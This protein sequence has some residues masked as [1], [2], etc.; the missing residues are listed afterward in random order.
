MDKEKI[1]ITYKQIDE[2]GKELK[3]NHK[4][5]DNLK[6]GYYRR[7]SLIN[8]ETSIRRKLR[9]LYSYL[10]NIGN[11]SANKELQDI[12]KKFIKAK[13][14]KNKFSFSCDG[15]DFVAIQKD[16]WNYH[17]TIKF[18]HLSDYDIKDL[19]NDCERISGLKV[20]SWFVSVSNYVGGGS[21]IKFHMTLIG[22]S[23]N[24]IKK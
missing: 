21:D 5:I 22:K 8:R 4:E 12:I 17:L 24:S 2:L 7:E 13:E 10:E 3:E 18:H 6:D 19:I 23:H 14:Y 1:K 16:G 20:K 15:H 9:R 11:Y